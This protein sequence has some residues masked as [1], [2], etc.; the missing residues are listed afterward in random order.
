MTAATVAGRFATEPQTEPLAA[1][2]WPVIGTTARVVVTESALLAPA[3]AVVMAELTALDA[4]CSRFRA[5]SEVRRLAAGDGRPVRVSAVLADA[6]DVALTA[7]RRT[8]GD[9]DP[10]VG[11]AL[12]ELGYDRDFAEVRL[13][14]AGRTVRVRTRLPGWQRVH[15]DLERRLLTVP[16]GTVLDLGA[17]A[18]AAAADRCAARI[19]AELGCGVLV[20]L[21]G[22]IATAGPAP[23]PAG[24]VVAVQDRPDQPADS[25]ACVIT[26]PAGGAL[27]TSS[28]A[29]RSWQRGRYALHHILDP[30]TLRP[31]P[32]IWRYATVAAASCLAANTASTVALIR[33]RA[34]PDW[35][36]G[37]DVDARLVAVDGT[38]RTVG[39]W[40]TADLP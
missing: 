34:A 37:Q 30:R 36:A 10:T 18:K 25:T 16:A 24:W 8:E 38:L 29:S 22:D 28:T 20:S 31:A 27:A 39:A 19:G 17:T 15:L 40:P 6:V 12:A 3:R 2:E 26:L 13:R 7:A 9:L 14:P 23:G 11:A 33:G 4:A 35:L 1:T 21:G 32:V 5:D